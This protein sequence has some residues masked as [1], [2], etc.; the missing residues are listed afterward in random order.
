[1]GLFMGCGAHVDD[2][3]V[4]NCCHSLNQR[5]GKQHCNPTSANENKPFLVQLATV[6]K[7]IGCHCPSTTK[8]GRNQ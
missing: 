6:N 3:V 4:A 8:E 7:H 2:Q 1:M 5:H